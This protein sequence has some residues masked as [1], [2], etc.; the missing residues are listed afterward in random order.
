MSE[1]PSYPPPMQP[2]PATYAAPYATIPP[3]AAPYQPQY[4]VAAPP[5]LQQPQIIP[6]NHAAAPAPPVHPP[7]KN[8]VPSDQ[9]MKVHTI[10]MYNLNYDLTHD[11]LLR[12]CKQY[13]DISQ[14]IFPLVRKG[15]GFC[16]YYD[17]RSAERAVKEMCEQEL[18]GRPVKT[19]FAFRPPAHSKRDLKELCSTILVKSSKG[20][21]SAITFD[22][23]KEAMSSFGEL[24]DAEEVY[25]DSFDKKPPKLDENANKTPESNPENQKSDESNASAETKPRKLIKGQWIVKYFDLRDAQ[26]CVSAGTVKYLDEE[27]SLE[28]ILDDI[29]E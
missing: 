14:L 24:R 19:N 1:Y 2:Y 18:N 12:F 8:H 9:R 13:G 10:F 11:Q 16:T 27:L 26:K 5:L 21:D 28:F 7:K 20:E 23:I 17:L 3:V 15:M 25:D 29:C 4:P 22:Q 6:P